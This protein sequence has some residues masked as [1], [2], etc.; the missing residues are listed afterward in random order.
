MKGWACHPGSLRGR[1]RA[2]GVGRSCRPQDEQLDV[3]N[4]VIAT[5]K[6]SSISDT[7][8]FDPLLVVLRDGGTACFLTGETLTGDLLSL[9]AE[10]SAGSTEMS[11]ASRLELPRLTN[12]NSSCHF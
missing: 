8:A 9:S 2:F 12:H 3:A 1:R 10:P 4:T 5:E 11:K 7:E 6:D